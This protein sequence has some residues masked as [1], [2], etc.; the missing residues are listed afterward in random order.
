VIDQIRTNI[1][2]RLAELRTE[3]DKLEAALAKLDPRTENPARRP[4]RRKPI[5]G[6]NGAASEAAPAKSTPAKPGTTRT[7]ARAATAA[8][9]SA[10]TA[11]GS[12]KA[13]VL[14][15]L[16]SDRAMTAGEVA[17]ATGLGRAS[18][19][20]TLSKLAKSGAVIKAER[21]YSLHASN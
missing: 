9:T 10:R 2:E 4:A 5:S 15:T 6:A 3:A 17:K 13:K 7:R 1:E 16:S 21:G 8:G 19:S 11:P 20:T 14:A 12:T 18:V